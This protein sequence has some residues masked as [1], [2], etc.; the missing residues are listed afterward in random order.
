MLWKERPRVRWG[1]LGRRA[2]TG[3]AAENVALV[4]AVKEMRAGRADLG[5]ECSRGGTRQHTRST[6]R[7]G[8]KNKGD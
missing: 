8:K 4:E 3:V 7:N 2:V 6:L 5:E 1:V